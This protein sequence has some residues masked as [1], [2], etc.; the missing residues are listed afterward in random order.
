M[1][2]V[3]VDWLEG[4]TVE[5]K[6]ALV[7]AI[8]EAMSNIGRAKTESVHVILN[9]IPTDSW[10]KGGKLFAHPQRNSVKDSGET[11]SVAA[12][13][14]PPQIDTMA[15]LLEI[16]SQAQ[17]VFDLEQPRKEGM[18]IFPAHRP[19]Y[20]YFL[21]RR[22]EDEYD[23]AEGGSRTSASGLIVCAEHSGTHI[24]AICHQAEDLKL[25]G[26]V[27]AGDTQT[28][29]G[30]ARFGVEEIPPIVA[31]GVLLDVAA[32]QGVDRLESGYAV[33]GEDLERCCT[34]QDIEI[35]PGEVV[36][37]R[38]GNARLYWEDPE[39]Y[40]QGPGMAASASRW[41]AEKR[42]LAVGADNVAWDVVGLRDPDLN[43]TLPGHLILLAR[44]GIYIVENL[45]LEELA[46]AGR[47]RFL[48]LCTPLKFV[49]ATGS[50]VRPLAIVQQETS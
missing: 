2:V 15:G 34:S 46:A 12:E 1:A 16:G 44:R 10:G 25:L 6:H 20:S 23:P 18:P 45:Q 32:N 4:R 31:S 7:E 22:H 49:G 24:D 37:V 43:V 39:S 40:L 47:H 5:Q 26:D 8:T 35:S 48:F 27:S 38:T 36:L 41:L 21:H 50:P 42:V 11:S 17:R 29:R 33:T 14:L 9:D 19:G 3:R 30:F 13:G 28:S